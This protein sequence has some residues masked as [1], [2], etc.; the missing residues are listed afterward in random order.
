MGC[1]FSVAPTT[2]L[3]EKGPTLLQL[4]PPDRVLTE[5]DG[6]F[7]NLEGRS[8]F[9]WDVDSAY[10]VLS[11][12]RA[13]EARDVEQR[14]DSNL[15]RLASMIVNPDFVPAS[16]YLRFSKSASRRPVATIHAARRAF[17]STSA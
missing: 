11:D 9:P 14:I 4:M 16:Y 7:V 13:C 17:A 15:R 3:G 5:T 10:P 6:P 8:I 1:W 2:L 12:I